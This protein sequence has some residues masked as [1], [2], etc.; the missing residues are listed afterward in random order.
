MKRGFLV[1]VLFLFSISL[2]SAIYEKVTSTPSDWSGR[3]LIVCETENVAFDGSL[4]TLEV[5]SNNKTVTIQDSRIFVAEDNFYFTIEKDGESYRVKSASGYYIGFTKKGNGLSSSQESTLSNYILFDKSDES[6]FDVNIKSMGGSYLRCDASS[7]QKSFRYYESATYTNQKAIQLY[8]LVEG[9][10]EQTYKVTL[11]D[12]GI[13]YG[14][15]LEGTFVNLPVV[16]PILN[17]EC[18]IVGWE[19]AG[20]SE[21]DITEDVAEVELVDNLYIPTQDCSLYAVY[22]QFVS[23]NIDDYTFTPISSKE[24]TSSP[25]LPD[26]AS[27]SFNNTYT[28]NKVQITSGNTQTWT[29]AGIDAPLT[30]VSASMRTNQSSGNGSIVITVDGVELYKLDPYTRVYKHSN[31]FSDRQFDLTSTD[32]VGD[33]VVT[34]KASVNS[35]YCQS[36]TITVGKDEFLYNSNPICGDFEIESGDVY[37]VEDDLVLNT[38]TIKSDRDEAGEMKVET[39]AVTA[40][41]VIVEKTI[42]DSRWYFFS[43]PFDCKLADVVAIDNDGKVLEYALDATSGDYVINEYD[44][45]RSNET[46]KAWRELL[47]TEHTLNAGQGYII[48]YFGSGDVTVKFKS[49]GSQTISI[50]I[51]KKLNYTDTWIVDGENSTRG[52]NLIGLPY[53]QQVEGSLTPE[54]VTIPN[55]DGKTYTQI[56][57]VNANIAPFTSFFVQTKEAPEFVVSAINSA[58]MLRTN[59]LINKAIISLTDANGGEDQTTV[60]N[61]QNATTDYEIGLDLVKWI[62]YASL[63][64]IY[65]IQGD[66]M[67]AFN[68]L[69]MDNSTI[70][71][72]G[73]YAHD[74]GEYTFAIDEKSM[75]NLQDLVLYDTD[76]DVAIRLMDSTYSIYL[77]KGVHEDRFDIRLQQRISTNCSNIMGDIKMWTDGGTLNMN[78]LPTDAVI[79][80]YDAVGRIVDVLNPTSQLV[81]YDFGIRGVY[82]VVIC[83][84]IGTI[85]FKTIY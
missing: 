5:A 58:P 75:G 37:V 29:I 57:Y 54:F 26:G 68:S 46:G 28:S 35:L 43:L 3:Y 50:P 80:I 78:N 31:V 19:F 40:N 33:I 20:W 12:R 73:I 4:T 41:S 17:L 69:A 65:S 70:I 27:I 74:S 49:S 7:N 8:R 38:L 77:E 39:G 23:S 52:F 9:I 21:T 59:A 16:G 14:D 53:Y 6:T 22:K 44:Q 83:S 25:A 2:F 66:D 11:Y 56:E 36:L 48:G 18:Q 30:A 64:Q 45:V 24:A 47:G 84:S 60:I 55:K 10:E 1:V 71:P 85:V 62:G 82:N 51:N 72:L 81:S 76:E 67:L 79:Y 42:D 13:Q 32:K 61:N 63:P 15:V 34:I